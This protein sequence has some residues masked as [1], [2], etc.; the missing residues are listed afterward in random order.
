MERIQ[1]VDVARYGLGRKMVNKVY[2]LCARPLSRNLYVS[3]PSVHSM[4]VR[5]FRPKSAKAV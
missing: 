2:Q 5:E 3:I 4:A 1:V